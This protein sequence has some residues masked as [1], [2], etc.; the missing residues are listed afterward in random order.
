MK[1]AKGE[2]VKELS[3]HSE[4]GEA[5]RFLV[6]VGVKNGVDQY[7][8][9]GYGNGIALGFLVTGAFDEAYRAFRDAS[10]GPKDIGEPGDL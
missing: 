2:R 8:A 1:L 9:H 10:I 4:D 7:R 5:H 6:F 3:W